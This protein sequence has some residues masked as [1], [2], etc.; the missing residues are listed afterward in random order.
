MKKK[1]SIVCLVDRGRLIVV[2]FRNSCPFT[3]FKGVDFRFK[4]VRCAISK[5][6]TLKLTKKAAKLFNF[7]RQKTTMRFVL[8]AKV[9]INNKRHWY[10]GLQLPNNVFL[11]E[12]VLKSNE[13]QQCVKQSD[14]KKKEWTVGK[15]KQKN[16]KPIELKKRLNEDDQHIHDSTEKQK[17]QFKDQYFHNFQSKQPQDA[18][19]NQQ[20]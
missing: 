17:Q 20:M 8:I 19:L 9:V 18:E 10:V 14:N 16:K 5:I 13:D 3:E 11:N 6:E 12:I 2:S 4:A 1:H 15:K 7:H